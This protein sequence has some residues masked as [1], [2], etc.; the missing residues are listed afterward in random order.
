MID[1]RTPVQKITMAM[2]DARNPLAMLDAR[3]S[4]GDARRLQVPRWRRYDGHAS[5]T[6]PALRWA[7]TAPRAPLIGS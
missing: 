4:V 5:D 2:L 6:D 1:Q 3:K 7:V